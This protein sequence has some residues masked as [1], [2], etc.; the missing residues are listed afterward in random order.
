[1]TSFFV[2][3]TSLNILVLIFDQ[4]LGDS[5]QSL[6]PVTRRQRQRIDQ[7]IRRGS[8]LAQS[9][10]RVFPPATAPFGGPGIND[11]LVSPQD[12]S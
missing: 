3:A 1:M 7:G 8:D 10:L 9:D 5:F 2:R 6:Q 11:S 12:A 4:L